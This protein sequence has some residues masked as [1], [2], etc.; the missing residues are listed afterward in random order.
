MSRTFFPVYIS[1]LNLKC[2][3][4]PREERGWS[5]HAQYLEDGSV[6]SDRMG[7]FN[8]VVR[9]LYGAANYFALQLPENYRVLIDMDQYIDSFTI[10]NNNGDR[11]SADPWRLGPGFRRVKPATSEADHPSYN[12][13]PGHISE[14]EFVDQEIIRSEMRQKWAN[15]YHRVAA[16]IP[17]EVAKANGEEALGSGE[18]L[19]DTD[20]EMREVEDIV[21]GGGTDEATR[22]NYNAI[23]PPISG[24]GGRPECKCLFH[25]L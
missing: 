13:P 4:L 15:Y 11:V 23:A 9:A 1:L 22:R 10:I 6:I 17:Y 18:F 14:S 8:F 12:S 20:L 19:D 16:H 7:H 24:K 25:L 21:E 5:E 3:P 2:R